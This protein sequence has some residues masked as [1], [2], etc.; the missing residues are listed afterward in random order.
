MPSAATAEH[1][2]VTFV[3]TRPE[4]IK[5]APVV[6]ELRRLEIPSLLISTGQHREMLKQA[7]DDLGLVPD[8]D[9]GLMKPN[10]SL[11][12]LSADVLTRAAALLEEVDPSYVV[13]QGDTTTVAMA[14]LAAFYR[15]VPVAHVE[16]GLR[17]HRPYDPFPEEMN[18]SVVGRLASLHFAP[19]ESARRNLLRE[20][21]SE[22]TIEVTGNTVIDSLY[23][24]RDLVS[25]L[26]APDLGLPE[27]VDGRPFALVTAHR[28]ENLGDGMRSV[29]QGLRRLAEELSGSLDILYPVHLNPRV[30]NAAR[31]E[32]EGLANVHLM[33]PVGYRAFVKLLSRARLII[34]DS[35][36]VQEE[37]TALGVPTLVTRLTSERPEAIESGVATLVGTDAAKLVRSARAILDSDRPSPVPHPAFGDGHAGER[38]V[39]S[40]LRHLEVSA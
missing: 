35:G 20:G 15:Q 8:L 21:I 22:S 28:R 39:A 19:T 24:M 37:A 1:P 29:F 32:L 3:G 34:T 38:I 2:V 7:L 30:G 27:W 10:Q 6:R 26:P 17:T 36:G 40:L 11:S 14:A 31:A 13:V 33:P 9:F 5:L 25:G 16:A 18:R 12:Q 4:V 23:T